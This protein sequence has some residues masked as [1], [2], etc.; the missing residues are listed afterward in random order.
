MKFLQRIFSGVRP[1]Y[2]IR[3]YLISLF[4]FG[5]MLSTVLNAETKTST[6]IG[7]IVFSTSSAVL[8][9]FAK[10]VWDELRDLAFGNNIIF[11]NAV[12]LLI[13]KLFVNVLLW[14]GA[15]FIAPIG[16]LYLWFRTRQSQDTVEL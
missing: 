11:M 4:F 16:I 8:F 15:V 1:I 9:P 3:S 10:L 13:L 7:T 12:F 2:L 14:G 5:L 6:P